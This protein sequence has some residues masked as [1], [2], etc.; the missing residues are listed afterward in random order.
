MD[1]AGCRR[2]NEVLIDPLYRLGIRR[3]QHLLQYEARLQAVA[4]VL[5]F[6]RSAT[7]HV[8]DSRGRL[9]GVKEEL[10]VLKKIERQLEVKDAGMRLR[11]FAEALRSS[12][13]RL[14]SAQYTLSGGYV[15][16]SEVAM[17]NR[18]GKVQSTRRPL[19]IDADSD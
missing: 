16:S 18:A 7:N 4:N 13:L 17:S 6:H 8:T 3:S 1:L 11:S 19:L 2:K 15:G 12:V 5:A 9:S 14:Q 10:K